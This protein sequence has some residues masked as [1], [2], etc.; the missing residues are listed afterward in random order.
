MDDESRGGG[1]RF[2]RRVNA[3]SPVDDAVVRRGVDEVS[4]GPAVGEIA[5]SRLAKDAE[6]VEAH[7]IAPDGEH[8]IADDGQGSAWESLLGCG[9]VA[10][11]SQFVK[12]HV[13][14]RRIGGGFVTPAGVAGETC[15]R[16]RIGGSQ[17]H[18]RFA[19][20]P[21]GG[22]AIGGVGGDFQFVVW[23][24]REGVVIVQ[25]KEGGVECRSGGSLEDCKAR[26][27]SG[28]GRGE[29]MEVAVVELAGLR[30]VGFDC[31]PN[32]HRRG[33]REGG[34][35]AQ[36][37]AGGGVGGDRHV[38]VVGAPAERDHVECSDGEVRGGGFGRDDGVGV[39]D[40]RTGHCTGVGPEGDEE[41]GL[42]VRVVG[43]CVVTLCGFILDRREF[44]RSGECG[45]RVVE[46]AAD[47][48][49]LV[50]GR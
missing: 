8:D 49:R 16:A 13:V 22:E 17:P 5:D 9:I 23:E 35:H 29:E 7:D 45:E 4:A 50:L 19:D 27:R 42:A 24:V 39:E 47:E 12:G 40:E 20:K 44:Q 41:G 34:C 15:V 28:V 11:R 46:E 37:A 43:L 48:I 2:L 21:E 25:R 6:V 36:E 3:D 10:G 32:H 38:E 30:S 31:G 26:R 18:G 1:V 14:F 33:E